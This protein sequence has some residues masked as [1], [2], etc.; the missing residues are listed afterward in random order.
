MGPL[1]NPQTNDKRSG[2]L[3]LQFDV[4][5]E[6]PPLE[7]GAVEVRPAGDPRLGFGAV[8]GGC[9]GA[10]G[11]SRWALAGHMGPLVPQS[12]SLISWQRATHDQ[13]TQPH[14]LSS[15][16]STHDNQFAARPIPAGTFLGDYTGDLLGRAAFFA[17]CECAGWLRGLLGRVG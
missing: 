17:R 8:R 11:L 16:H 7:A 14:A 15:T 10:Q 5:S 3:Y 4:P 6:G 9:S 12:G 13:Q 1:T 2:R